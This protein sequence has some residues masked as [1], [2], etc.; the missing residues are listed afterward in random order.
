MNVVTDRATTKDAQAIA[1][2]VGCMA[3]EPNSVIF[4]AGELC[5][6]DTTEET[7]HM[8]RQ[9]AIGGFTLLAQTQRSKKKGGP[10]VVGLLSV[11]VDEETKCHAGLQLVIAQRYQR[12][13][14]GHRLMQFAMANVE[15]EQAIGVL[16]CRARSDNAQAI[17]LGTRFGLEE[18]E[19]VRGLL[20]I[21]GKPVNV[22]VKVMSRTFHRATPEEGKPFFYLDDILTAIDEANDN[23]T[24]YACLETGEVECVFDDDM[25]GLSGE[26]GFDPDE[27]E[28]TWVLLPDRFDIDDW[29]TMRDFANCQNDTLRNR[30]LDIIHRRGAYRN[31]KNEC[32]RQGLLD[33]YYTF[34]D[35]RHREVAVDWLERNGCVWTEG[36]R[37]WD[38]RG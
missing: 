13:G 15:R 17:R 31:F 24:W 22:N 30:L 2:F 18:I 26:E 35:R 32:D 27:A 7:T 37:P 9:S 33:D 14:I 11:D 19:I 4:G 10:E 36:R 1:N 34:Q 6:R 8:E 5:V 12:Q 23:M 16:S 20:N 21:G 25:F 28:G 29:A 3:Y 38:A